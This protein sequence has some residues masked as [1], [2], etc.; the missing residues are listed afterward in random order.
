MTEIVKIF[1]G[2]RMKGLPRKTP[3]D[4]CPPE[5]VLVT[6]A[7]RRS[8]GRVYRNPFPTK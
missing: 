6:W 2:L 3:S 4:V 1:S 8:T 5:A 7:Q